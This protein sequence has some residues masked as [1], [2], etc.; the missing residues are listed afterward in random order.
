MGR[1]FANDI[2][3]KELA[4]RMH[5]NT[6]MRSTTERQITQPKKKKMD[7]KLEWSCLQRQPPKG[8]QHRQGCSMP[9]TVRETHAKPT[10]TQHFTPTRVTT[11]FETQKQKRLRERVRELEPLSMAGGT[12]K[13]RGLCGEL[14]QPLGKVHRATMAPGIPALSLHRRERHVQTQRGPGCSH[15]HH[16]RRAEGRKLQDPSADA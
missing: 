10:V 11:F 2:V 1:I 15:L 9:Q 6:V 16:P 7:K 13:R 12:V 8:Q 3:H 5:K 4:S 14:W